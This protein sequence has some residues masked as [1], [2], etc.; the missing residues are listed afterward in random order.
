MA[1]NND[2]TDNALLFQVLKEVREELR[3]QHALLLE[4]INQGRSLERH[5]DATLLAI[6]KQFEEL[7]DD[8]ELMIKSELMG[9]VG[10]FELRRSGS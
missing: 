3:H 1:G 8:L 10:D 2:S 9:L 6:D 7:K 4:S 5:V